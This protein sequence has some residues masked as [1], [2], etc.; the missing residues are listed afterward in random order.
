MDLEAFKGV[1]D[2]P[3]IGPTGPLLPRDTGQDGGRVGL[4]I[5]RHLKL[6]RT[7][8]RPLDLLKRTERG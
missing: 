2:V 3:S 7:D 8:P 1:E 5:S 4:L 6:L